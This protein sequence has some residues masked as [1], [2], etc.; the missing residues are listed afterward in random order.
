MIVGMNLHF[1][2]KAIAV[3]PTG[4]MN[5]SGD[6]LDQVN[7]KQSR[8]SNQVRSE[9]Q[10]MSSLNDL[11]FAYAPVRDQTRDLREYL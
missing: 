5:L 3:E 2:M 7:R 1:P 8:N 4:V 11:E 9:E 6:I 10:N